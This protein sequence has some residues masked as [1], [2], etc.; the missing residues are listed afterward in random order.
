MTDQKVKLSI[1]GLYKG[2][3]GPI[4]RGIDLDI[5]E[6]ESFVIIG[7]SGTG[8]TVLIKTIIGLLKPDSGSIMLD[9]KDIVNI[10]KRERSELMGKFGFMFQ[11]GALF[12][13]LKIWENI[14]FFLIHNKNISVEEAR[15]I[16]LNKLKE[17]GLDETVLD[18]YPADLSGG[19]KK[20]VSFARAIVNNPEIIFFDEPTSGL[21][22]IM[23]NVVN[24]LIIQARVKYGATTITISHDIS[25]TRKIASRVSMLYQGKLEWIG[26]VGDMDKA[27]SPIFKQFITGSTQGPITIN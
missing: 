19:M 1:K 9:D 21:D 20:R 22:P 11:D 18:L 7:G 26:E 8:K 15:D 5:F 24:D 13:S 14:A 25:S 4:L 16:S 27:K 23:R 3:K 10:S 12:D 17:V 6:N 2:F